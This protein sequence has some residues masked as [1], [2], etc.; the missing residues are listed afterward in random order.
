MWGAGCGETLLCHE[1]LDLTLTAPGLAW[2]VL[3][4]ENMMLSVVAGE[5]RSGAGQ[6]YSK[7]PTVTHL[8]REG[9]QI[10]LDKTGT[11]IPGRSR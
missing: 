3:I 2:L 1:L 7:S 4:D 10:L 9:V 11:R 6:R 8:Q 5:R